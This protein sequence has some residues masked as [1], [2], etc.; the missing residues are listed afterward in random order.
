MGYQTSTERVIDDL[1]VGIFRKRK[2]QERIAASA[3]MSQSAISRRLSGEVSPT[4]SEL[5]R[6]AGAAGYH[7]DVTLRDSEESDASTE[8][9][10]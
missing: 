7:L 9:V 2:S 10:A 6:I 1:R 3:G 8:R 5:E 4:I